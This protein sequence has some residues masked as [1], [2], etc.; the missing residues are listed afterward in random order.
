MCHQ[1]SEG[2][3]A[4]PHGKTLDT[5]NGFAQDKGQ[6]RCLHWGEKASCGVGDFWGSVT[7]VST[8]GH[9]HL[10]EVVAQW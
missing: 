2:F 8:L 7:F 9:R 4:I 5:A 6:W 3:F 1:S 10:L